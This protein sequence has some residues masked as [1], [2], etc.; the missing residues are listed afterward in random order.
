MDR[1]RPVPG[2]HRDLWRQIGPIRRQDSLQSHNN[3]W[4]FSIALKG[5]LVSCVLLGRGFSA[6]C[7]FVPGRTHLLFVLY[8]EIGL[9]CW[10][11]VLQM[12]QFFLVI[13]I[14]F[15]FCILKWNKMLGLCTV[16]LIYFLFCILKW[17]KMLGLCT[18]ILIYFLFCVLKWN[19]MLGLCTVILIYF[20]FC[21]L[22]WNKM[23]GLCTVILIYFLF[24]ILKLKCVLSI[25]K[26]SRVFDF[27]KRRMRSFTLIK[28]SRNVEIT[29]HWTHVGKL[30]T[31]REFSHRKYAF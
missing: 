8:P 14:Y 7:D 26:F 3:S 16:I 5:N 21:I 31:S 27:A 28:P 18:V 6:V 13:L 1:F 9:K 25:W 10:V 19:K 17:N 24:C 12:Y 30:C 29:P 23:L 11:C 2:R 15:L 20:L 22:K 4:Y